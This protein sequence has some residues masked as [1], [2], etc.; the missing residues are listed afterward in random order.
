MTPDGVFMLR[1]PCRGYVPAASFI[2]V[3]L[4]ATSVLMIGWRA[5][6][7]AVTPEVGMGQN[8]WFKQDALLHE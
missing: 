8:S 3:A 7:A 4:G 1:L 6:L 5:A 2:Y